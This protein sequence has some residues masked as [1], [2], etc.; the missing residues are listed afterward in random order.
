MRTR[1]AITRCQGYEYERVLK[2]VRHSIDLLGG[3][4]RFV[5]PGQSVLLKPN[6]LIASVPEKGVTT[7]PMVV[8]AVMEIV[9]EAGGVPFVG[10]SPS[11]GSAQRVAAKSRI[12]QVAEA[13]GCPIVDFRETVQVRTPEGFTFR[14]F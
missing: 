1:I 4:G 11:F 12:A 9:K 2:A 10:D 3:I 7:H 13:M 6:L 5:K 14:R 8:R